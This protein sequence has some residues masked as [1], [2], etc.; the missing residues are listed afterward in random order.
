MLVL[1]LG[2]VSERVRGLKAGG[3]DYLTKPFALSE[4]MARVEALLRRPSTEIRAAEVHVGSVSLDLI[5]RS[6]LAAW[7]ADRTS[8]ARI[9]TTA[10]FHAAAGAVDHTW[11]AAGAHLELPFSTSKQSHRRSYR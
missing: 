5:E 4:L 7:A 8:G 11:D 10:L 2:D 3:D 1:D 6:V 9:Q